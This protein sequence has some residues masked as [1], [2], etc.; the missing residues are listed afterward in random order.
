VSSLSFY[1]RGGSAMSLH[2]ATSAAGRRGALQGA[3]QHSVAS[4]RQ[5][6]ER[7]G[8][9]APHCG[10]VMGKLVSHL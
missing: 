6:R 3:R 10:E 5:H 9:R 7:K 8:M 4:A 2:V 1:L